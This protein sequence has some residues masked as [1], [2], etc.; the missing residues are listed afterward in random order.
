M[1]G[2]M[3][4]RGPGVGGVRG[5]RSGARYEGGRGGGARGGGGRVM[6]YGAHF[7]CVW[8]GWACMYV[9]VCVFMGGGG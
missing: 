5:D 9:C 4:G 1:R 7:C 3:A 2:G 8:A 6:W